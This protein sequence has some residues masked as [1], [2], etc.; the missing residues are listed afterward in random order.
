MAGGLALKATTNVDEVLDDL[1][2]YVRA[3]N[4][5]A[6]PVALN[7][8]ADLAKT[9]GLRAVSDDYEIGP[10]TFEKYVSVEVANAGHY[11][12][13][14]R[15]RGGALPLYVFKPTQGAGG[16]T[17]TIKGKRAFIPHAFLAR[18]PSGH[19]GVFARG[20]YGG[21]G[22]RQ[23]TGQSFGR[24]QFGERRLPINEL[25]T[26]GPAFGFAVEQHGGPPQTSVVL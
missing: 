20:A 15:A 22:L 8:L 5:S 7:K 13:S 10:R 4:G 26:F 14:V 23:A 24:F 9:A 2:R 17:V 19:L 11:R 21:K 1:D 18:M 25:Y 3:V 16:V 12:A 6:I